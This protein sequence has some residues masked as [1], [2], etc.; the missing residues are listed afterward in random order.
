VVEAADGVS[1]FDQFSGTYAQLVDA[2][3]AITG[4]TSEYFASYKAKFIAQQV[5]SQPDC[6]ILDYGCGVGLVCGQIKKYL[7]AARVE[8]YD[9]SEASLE[10]V[11]PSLRAQGIFASRISALSGNYDV[12]LFANVLHHIEPKD[13]QGAV[14]EAVELLGRGGTL[15]IFE[16]NPR[17]PLTRRAVDRCA[18]DENALLLP[19]RESR[20]YLERSGLQGVRLD[21]IVFFSHGLRWLRTFEKFLGWCS[22][23]AQYVVQGIR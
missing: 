14:S 2:S 7:P 12:V 11:D 15:V 13:R 18:F 9:V 16:H 17:N 1:E 3:I 19:P 23:G 8:G 22:L 10:R 21:Y 4:E 5:I 20:A 6:K